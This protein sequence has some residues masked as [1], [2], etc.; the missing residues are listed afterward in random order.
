MKDIR[1][2][3]KISRKIDGLL[4]TEAEVSQQDLDDALFYAMSMRQP[5]AKVK[6]EKLKRLYEFQRH[7]I[8]IRTPT[9]SAERVTAKQVDEAHQKAI[10]DPSLKNRAA[11]SILKR[12]LSD[13]EDRDA[14]LAEIKRQDEQKRR[15]LAKEQQAQSEEQKKLDEM[16]SAYK[17]QVQAHNAAYDALNK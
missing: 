3:I 17:K 14:E 5:Q 16:Q 6:F 9:P 4:E 1:E 7:E 12:A 15:E 13:Q 10:S 2:L 11:W 8:E